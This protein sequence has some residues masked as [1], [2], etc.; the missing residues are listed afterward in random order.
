M[1]S[2]PDMGLDFINEWYSVS[3]HKQWKEDCLCQVFVLSHTDRLHQPDVRGRTERY[4]LPD[5]N[6]RKKYSLLDLNPI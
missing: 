1:D 4:S 6:S 2:W 3:L 5:L